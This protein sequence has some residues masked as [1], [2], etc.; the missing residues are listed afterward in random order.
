MVL[1]SL[2]VVR[3]LEAVVDFTVGLLTLVGSD[4]VGALAFLVVFFLIYRPLALSSTI[5]PSL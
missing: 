5:S 4:L 3:R 2:E 1:A